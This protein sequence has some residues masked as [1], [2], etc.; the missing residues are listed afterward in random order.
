M[1]RTNENR[2]KHAAE[3]LIESRSVNTHC[4]LIG[5]LPHIISKIDEPKSSASPGHPDSD[6][7]SPTSNPNIKT[8]PII[9]PDIYGIVNSYSLK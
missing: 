4:P 9:V 2:N 6:L 5:N 7:I 1:Y 3:Q 8:Q